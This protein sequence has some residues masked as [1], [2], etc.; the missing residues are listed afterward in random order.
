MEGTCH[1]TAQGAIVCNGKAKKVIDPH[2]SIDFGTLIKDDFMIPSN[3]PQN[4]GKETQ[5]GA[6]SAEKFSQPAWVPHTEPRPSMWTERPANEWEAKAKEINAYVA[7][8][9]LDMQD[10]AKRL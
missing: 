7:Q 1:Y 4:K 2:T 3:E 9:D 6:G 5:S 8:L 10:F